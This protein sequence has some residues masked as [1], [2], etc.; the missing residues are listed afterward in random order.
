[1]KRN[2]FTLIELMVVVAIIGILTALVTVNLSDARERARDVQRKTDLKAIQGALELYKNDQ[3]PQSYPATAT[4]QTDLESSGYIK[5]VPSD[6]TFAQSGSW[7]DYAYTRN[8]GDSL[9]Y[10][11]V[12]CLENTAD[13]DKD[14]TDTCVTYGVSY[15]LNEP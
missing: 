10:T 6:P 7:V 3:L 1:M 14:D 4:W 2:G 15:T 9:E 8:V 5:E 13:I 11:L 12:G